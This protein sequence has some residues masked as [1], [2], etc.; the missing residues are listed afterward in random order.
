[1]NDLI[2]LFLGMCGLFGIVAMVG[3]LAK[4]EIARAFAFG[5]FVLTCGLLILFATIAGSVPS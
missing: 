3:A 2:A 4:K 5:L 1:M